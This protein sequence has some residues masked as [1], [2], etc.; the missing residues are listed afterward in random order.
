MKKSKLKKEKEYSQCAVIVSLPD[1]K[2]SD[3]KIPNRI[4]KVKMDMEG[5]CYDQLDNYLGKG[6]LENG[7]LKITQD[8][9]VNYL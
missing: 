3:V 8:V 6:I 7:I 5:N 2:C 1:L 9:R 4:T